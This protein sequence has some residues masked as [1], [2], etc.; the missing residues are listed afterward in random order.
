MKDTLKIWLCV[1]AAYLG[2]GLVYQPGWTLITFVGLGLYAVAAGLAVNIA[3]KSSAKTEAAR[4]LYQFG[5]MPN[6]L[7]S[8]AE[9]EAALQ[10]RDQA[11]QALNAEAQAVVDRIRERTIKT[12]SFTIHE[13]D[14]TTVEVTPTKMTRKA[15][16]TDASGTVVP[17]TSEDGVTK[18]TPNE[19]SR[20]PKLSKRKP[21]GGDQ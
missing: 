12:D 11:A 6:P 16:L 3:R 9:V 18:I 21:K 1:T 20:S 4:D 14:G 13:A 8:D 2:G 10:A 7:P 5:G 19:I 15:T 17:L